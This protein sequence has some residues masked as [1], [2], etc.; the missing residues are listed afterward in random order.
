MNTLAWL[1]VS[2]HFD[3]L[4]ANL[5]RAVGVNLPRL[6]VAFKAVQSKRAVT[7]ESFAA[8]QENLLST[9]P[10]DQRTEITK[11]LDP[12]W[13]ALLPIEDLPGASDEQLGIE[14]GRAL[15][16]DPTR[17]QASRYSTSDEA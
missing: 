3:N 11:F 15:Q 14:Y 17:L 2:G 5:N 8:E 6:Q 10:S 1:K 16:G 12:Q 4:N 13:V 9:L 7:V